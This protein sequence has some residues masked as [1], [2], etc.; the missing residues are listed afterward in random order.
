MKKNQALGKH[1][2]NNRESREGQILR[3]IREA[4][5]LSQID[6]AKKLNLKAVDV[7]HF[8]NGRKFYTNDDLEMFLNEYKIEKDFW[9]KVF[10]L[11]I[12]NRQILNHLMLGL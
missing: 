6:V 9:E 7:D 4:R 3:Y 8:E 1:S 12:I 10:G 5:K 11:K 2:H